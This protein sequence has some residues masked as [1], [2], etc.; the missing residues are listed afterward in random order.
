M[1]GRPDDLP[2]ATAQL[3]GLGNTNEALVKMFSSP[4]LG[5]TP[6]GL[7]Y[8]DEKESALTDRSVAGNSGDQ[9]ANGMP[10]FTGS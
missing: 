1:D 2:L 3:F 10:S 5:H 6:A 8:E 9:I 7:K 4:N